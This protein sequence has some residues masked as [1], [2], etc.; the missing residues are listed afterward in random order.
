MRQWFGRKSD[1]GKTIFLM[2][3]GQKMLLRVSVPVPKT[4]EAAKEKG[5]EREFRQAVAKSF[6]SFERGGHW[7]HVGSA[8]MN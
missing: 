2:L 1:D 6:E 3:A 5:N 8:E 7:A 4:E